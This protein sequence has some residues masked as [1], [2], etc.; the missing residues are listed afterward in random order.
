[1]VLNSLNADG[2]RSRRWK[3]F[4]V[5]LTWTPP[6]GFL[7]PIVIVAAAAAAPAAAGWLTTSYQSRSA[8]AA[9]MGKQTGN[10]ILPM[11]SVAAAGSLHRISNSSNNTDT[12]VRTATF[13][14]VISLIGQGSR[15]CCASDIPIPVAPAR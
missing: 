13:S 2:V 12:T 11:V 10:Y 7:C 4:G 1:M 3:Q 9:A 6:H 15:C 14:F 8:I 5:A